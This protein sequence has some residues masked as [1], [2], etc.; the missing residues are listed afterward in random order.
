MLDDTRF[1]IQTPHQ[2]KITK[3][4]IIVTKSWPDMV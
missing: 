2:N 1:P 3:L 4:Q